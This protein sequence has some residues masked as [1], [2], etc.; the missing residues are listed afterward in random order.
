MSPLDQQASPWST[1]RSLTLFAT[2]S[3]RQIEFDQAVPDPIGPVLRRARARDHLGQPPHHRCRHGR[4]AAN[5]ERRRERPLRAIRFFTNGVPTPMPWLRLDAILL[6]LVS[7]PPYINLERNSVKSAWRIAVDAREDGV[8]RQRRLRTRC[9]HGFLYVLY[10]T[11]YALISIFPTDSKINSAKGAAA[12]APAK[13]A[14]IYGREK[15]PSTLPSSSSSWATPS[16]SRVPRYQNIPQIM[17]NIWVEDGFE[18][19]HRGLGPIIFGNLP[20]WAIYSSVY[21]TCKHLNYG[22][23][24]SFTFTTLSFTFFPLS[25][26]QGSFHAFVTHFGLSPHGSQ[27]RPQAQVRPRP[28]PKPDPKPESESDFT[29]PTPTFSIL[30]KPT[31]CPAGVDPQLEELDYSLFKPII[32]IGVFKHVPLTGGA[33]LYGPPGTGKTSIVAH[34]AS[35]ARVPVVVLRANTVHSKFYGESEK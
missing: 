8:P 17:R 26:F 18:G 7:V 24:I 33:I 30:S 13:D 9:C 11:I 10:I 12:V 3:T 1:R 31:A 35:A 25:L 32:R 2:I 29:G 20:T 15:S 4:E 19:F 23:S 21:D 6:M 28:K 27:V 5:D 16:P 14:L 34:V 22:P